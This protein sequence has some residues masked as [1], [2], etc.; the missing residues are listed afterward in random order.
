MWQRWRFVNAIGARYLDMTLVQQDGSPA[1]CDI[2]LFAK[3]GVY[4]LAM[5]RNVS[6]V[7]LPGAGRWGLLSSVFLCPQLAP[8]DALPAVTRNRL[9]IVAPPVRF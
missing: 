4:L 5:P 6:H 7:M 3:D 8:K 1:G 9:S 2:A